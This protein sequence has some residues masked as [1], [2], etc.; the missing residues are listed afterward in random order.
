MKLS[1][2]SSK[3]C[4]LEFESLEEFETF[5]DSADTNGYFDLPA[6]NLPAEAIFRASVPG[7]PRSRKIRPFKIS[8]EQGKYRIWLSEPP[9]PVEQPSPLQKQEPEEKEAAPRNLHEKIRNLPTSER[10]ALAMKADF[11]E[12]R[13]LIQEN[14]P[15]IHEFLLRNVRITEQEIATLARNPAAPMQTILAIA[16]NSTWMGADVVR[17]AIITNP[18]TPAAMVLQMMPTMSAGDLIRMHHSHHLRED[19]K[20]AVGR[21]IKKR[22]IKIP[23]SS[24]S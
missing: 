13:I 22:G 14:N 24:D 1:I 15:K 16:N 23:R 9:R 2:G 6:E 7:S 5:F 4:I 19:V 21:E 17:S 8:R 18:R 3:D 20:Q 12:R 11:H 10:V